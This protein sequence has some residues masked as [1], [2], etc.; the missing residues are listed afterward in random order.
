[1]VAFDTTTHSRDQLFSFEEKLNEALEDSGIGYVDGNDI[2]QGEFNIYCC[3]PRK[4]PL[5]AFVEKEVAAAGLL[6]KQVK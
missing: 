4:A 2:G 1:V 5:K 3:G 6:P